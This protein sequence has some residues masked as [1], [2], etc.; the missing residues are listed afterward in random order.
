[1]GFLFA[2]PISAKI[3]FVAEFGSAGIKV[4]LGPVGLSDAVHGTASSSGEAGGIWSYG[5][6]LWEVFT[7]GAEPLPGISPIERE[8]LYKYEFI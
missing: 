3:V 8:S 1:L 5:T 2:G 6:F 7:F 4:K